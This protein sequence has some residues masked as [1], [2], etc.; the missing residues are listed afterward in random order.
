MR[1]QISADIKDNVVCRWLQGEQ[2][3]KIAGDMQLGAG[4]VS[5]ILSEWK[6]EI[7]LPKAETLRQFATELRRVGI[8]ASECALGCRLLKLIGKLGIDVE[9][10][11]SFVNKVYKQ[12]LERNLMP[13]QIVDISE[14]ILA[15]DRPH[16]IHN[17]Q[18]KL[19][20]KLQ[21]AID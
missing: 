16:S 20:R 21:K 18:H 14:Q 8:N 13:H 19:K 9:S 17:C 6:E 2:R 7:G 12:C 15:L 1:E 10:L 5:A 4:T 3:D 11:E